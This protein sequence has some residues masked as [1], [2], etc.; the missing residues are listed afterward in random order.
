MHFMCCLSFYAVYYNFSFNVVHTTSDKNI[1]ANALS[2]GILNTFFSSISQTCQAPALVPLAVVAISVSSKPDQT[3]QSQKELFN[4][5]IQKAQHP[6]LSDLISQHSF[7][8]IKFVSNSTCSFFNLRKICCAHLW[9][10]WL[11]NM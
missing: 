3:Y 6:L 7:V 1:A 8:A 11:A 2:R 9:H 4:S 10:S 5:S